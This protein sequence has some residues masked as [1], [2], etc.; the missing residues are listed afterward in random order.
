MAYNAH[1]LLGHI[2][3]AHGF[4]GAVKI[5]LEEAFRNKIPE[6]ESV[7]LEIDG[8]PVP[9]FIS[10]SEVINTDIFRLKFRGY[11]SMEKINEFIGCKVYL[12]SAGKG[13]RKGL[14]SSG[15][16][17]F[18]VFLPG[19]RFL[20]TVTDTIENPG[21]ILLVMK[22]IKEKEILIPFHEDLIISFDKGKKLIEMDLPEGLTEIN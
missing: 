21:Q 19:N 12:T 11:D 7:F 14:N 4:D 18:T 17:G 10:E 13:R 9:F 16:T 20:G 3:K 8:K 6:M 15:L 1:I 2:L 22:S 5:K